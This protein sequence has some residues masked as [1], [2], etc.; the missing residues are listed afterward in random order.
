MITNEEFI[1]S[2]SEE[3]EQWKDIE[4]FE[5]YYQISNFG[6]VVALGR[7]VNHSTKGFK[8]YISPKIKSQKV[9]DNGYLEVSLH[10]EGKSTSCLVHRLVAKA[11]IENPHNL[12]F[13]DH[14]DRVR[15]NNH[16]SNLSWC[17]QSGNM[18]NPNTRKHLS[19]VNTGRRYPTVWKAV[20]Q[21]DKFSN[22]MIKKYDCIADTSKDGFRPCLVSQCCSGIH[23]YHA[24][25]RWMYL[26]NY[27]KLMEE[28][29][30]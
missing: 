1:K 3:N 16:Y 23:K 14:F 22:K 2:I 15:S 5:G 19:E 20:V 6:K 13:V 11:F 25:Y 28:S 24:K 30:K 9:R 17:N 12:P 8:R 4:G 18:A 27:E 21:L 29:Q 10:L 26:S 7:Y